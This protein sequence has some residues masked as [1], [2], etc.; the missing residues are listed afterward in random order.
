M[1]NI[2]GKLWHRKNPISAPSKQTE[3]IM[4]SRKYLRDEHGVLIPVP[5]P[6]DAIRREENR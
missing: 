6:I 2:E 5:E 1:I 3:L 4:K